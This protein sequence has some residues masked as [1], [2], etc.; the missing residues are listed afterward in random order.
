M[1]RLSRVVISAVLGRQLLCM[2]LIVSTFIAIGCGETLDDCI[3]NCES[4]LNRCQENANSSQELAR[5]MDQF[6][7]CRNN[8]FSGIAKLTKFQNEIESE[9]DLNCLFALD[10]NVRPGILELRMKMTIAG[11]E[12]LRKIANLGYTYSPVSNSVR[13][14]LNAAPKIL[15]VKN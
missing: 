8:C 7:I 3:D 1:E 12:T 4:V 13:G 6:S 15:V 10:E 2:V 14:G 5:C 9:L 11:D